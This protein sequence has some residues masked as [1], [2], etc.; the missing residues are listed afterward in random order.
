MPNKIDSNV[1]GLAYAEEAATIKTLP[2]TPVWYALEPNSYSDFGSQIK[3]VARKPI[4]ASRQLRKGV[5]VDLDASGGFNQDLTFSNLTRLLQGFFFADIREDFTTAP[6]NGTRI[7]LTATTS[8]NYTAA[9]GLTGVLANALVFA[10][11]FNVPANNGLKLISAAST[12]TVIATT[13]LTVETPPAAAELRVVGYQFASA[14]LD[15]VVTG[16]NAVLTRISG[17]FDFTTLGLL[18]GEWVYLGGDSA[19]VR[20]ANNAGFARVNSVTASTIVLDK[21]SWTPQ[22]E[23][24]TGK[25]VNLFFGSVLK[26]ESNPSLIKRRTY[27][28]ERQLGNDGVGIMSEYLVGAVPNEITINVAQAD[29]VTIDLSFVALDNE[30]RNGTTGVKSGTRVAQAIEPAFNTSSDVTRTKIALTVGG[31][32][33]TPLFAFATET[34]LTIKNNV[35]ANKAI[36]VVGG[37]DA[38]AGFFEVGGNTTAYFGD[39]AGVQAVRNN[40]DVTTDTLLQKKNRAIMFDVPLVG[41]GDGRLSVEQDQ[42]ITLP[43]ETMAG[44]SAFGHTLLFNSFYYLPD[45]AGGL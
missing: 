22:A 42:P 11:G 44:E 7:A 20:F 24:G 4:T 1:T 12:A 29:K 34:K 15:V 28:V 43:L 32:N 40:S 25:T 41:L 31:A 30:Q 45:V 36:G 21:T 8:T 2:G 23:V 37:F 38:T 13:G 3:T 27:Q 39:I 26:N 16:G 35:T 6:M 17:V 9:A 19:P 10:S 5:T 18:P 33:V 14:T